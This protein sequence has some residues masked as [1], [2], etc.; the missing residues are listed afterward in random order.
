MAQS[1]TEISDIQWKDYEQRNKLNNTYHDNFHKTKEGK[2][3][4][5]MKNY[6][7]NNYSNLESLAK[8]GK[9]EMIFIRTMGLDNCH[10]LEKASSH[11]YYKGVSMMQRDYALLPSSL[12]CYSILHW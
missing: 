6:I 4:Q 2:Y 10:A 7:D 8:E 9:G 5:R 3:Y 12:F 1:S 11:G